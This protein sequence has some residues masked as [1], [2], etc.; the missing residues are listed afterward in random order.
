MGGGGESDVEEK[1]A[2]E[3]NGLGRLLPETVGLGGERAVDDERVA[4]NPPWL[5]AYAVRE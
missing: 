2:G 4:D 3:V 1:V 5:R